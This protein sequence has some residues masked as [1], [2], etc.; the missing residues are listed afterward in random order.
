MCTLEPSGEHI[1]PHWAYS[2]RAPP[3]RIGKA[4]PRQ[5]KNKKRQS[6]GE[7]KAK[8]RQ[9][10]CKAG[11]KQRQSE[12]ETRDRYFAAPRVMS[13][14]SQDRLG[15]SLTILSDFGALLQQLWSNIGPSWPNLFYLGAI[16]KFIL[17]QLRSILCYLGPSCGILHP[18]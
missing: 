4:T 7:I 18:S 16:L 14:L 3:M 10:K 11:P 1:S 2:L 5:S 6:K 13:G 15:T 17:G 9:S 12:D 8:R